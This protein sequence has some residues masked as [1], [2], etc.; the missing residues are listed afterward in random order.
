MRLGCVSKRLP[1]TRCLNCKQIGYIYLGH[2][3][4][5]F[6]AHCVL[7]WD[8]SETEVSFNGTGKAVSELPEDML[9]R[10]SDYTEEVRGV[11]DF[12]AKLRV[13]LTIQAKAR[14]W[15]PVVAD[16]TDVG[17]LV[18]LA[19]R[20][21]PDDVE[22]MRKSLLGIRRREY[23]QAVSDYLVQVGCSGSGRLGAG[24]ELSLLNDLGKEDAESIANT[25]N[26]DLAH[27][28]R[29]IRQEVPTANR[30][31]FV[32]RLRAWERERSEWKG[33]QIALHTAMT[34]RQQAMVD[35]SEN[36]GLRPQ[37]QLQPTRAA[38]PICQGWINRGKVSFRVASNNPSPY[39]PGCVHFWK[40]AFEKTAD[41]EGLWNG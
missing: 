12:E 19:A 9:R 38:E 20:Q 2:G 24:A 14:Q 5:L 13:A 4:V 8:E 29:N 21:T 6:C 36:N 17:R 30:H 33:T 28:I 18:H 41:C 25:F 26:F 40:P 37:L 31:V 34:T 35:F 16:L 15:E 11:I 10:V 23:D 22:E 1:K 32:N 3:K 39:H 7:S 27:A